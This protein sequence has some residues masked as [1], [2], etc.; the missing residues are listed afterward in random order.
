[1]ATQVLVPVLGEAIGEA[2]VAA[3]LRQPGDPV[4]RGDELAELETDKAVLMLECPAD[5]VLIETLVAVGDMV[6]TGQLLAHV[7]KPGEQARA[8]AVTAASSA[9]PDRTD[10][11]HR[12]DAASTSPAAEAGPTRQRISPAAR[13]MARQ[14]GVEL[15]QLAPGK[16]GARITTQDVARLRESGASAPGTG[17]RLPHRRVALGDAQR[18]MAA[19]MAQSARDIPQFSVSMEVDATRLLCVKQDLADGGAAASMTALLIQLAARALLKHPLLNARFDGDVVVVY[20]TANMGVAVA[21]PQGLVVPVIHGVQDLSLAEIAGQLENL[22]QV[23]RT[24]R[25]T[26]AQVSDGTFT[27][28]NLGMYGVSQFVPL[29]NPPQA[30]ILGVGAA[31]PA[32]LPTAAGT[33]HIQRMTLTVTA[34]HRVVDGAAV[35]LFLGDLRRAIEEPTII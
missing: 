23:A 33:H 24:G 22:A 21:S 20:E 1:M 9:P 8:A 31:Q 35:A 3:W 25:L 13:R 16:P 34:D 11:S 2:R 28:T 14:H 26:L 32:V 4:R 17:V 27:L 19:R 30:A 10:R 15:A 5:G 7:G 12:S 6:T 29:V 18:T